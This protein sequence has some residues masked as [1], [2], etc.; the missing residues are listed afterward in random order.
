MYLQRAARHH[1]D[2]FEQALLQQARVQ[3]CDTVDR[4]AADNR[5]VGHADVRIAALFDQRDAHVGCL[6]P[7]REREP[8]RRRPRDEDAGA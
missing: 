3:L 8:D 5:Q 1:R 2:L 4:K 6:E 7:T